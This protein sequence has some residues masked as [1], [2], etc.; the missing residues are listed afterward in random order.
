MHVR[1]MD[2][3]VMGMLSRA[4]KMPSLDA[5]GPL[6]PSLSSATLQQERRNRHAEAKAAPVENQHVPF[7]VSAFSLVL[8]LTRYEPALGIDSQ[9][10]SDSSI[11]DKED[12]AEYC[13]EEHLGSQSHDHEVDADGLVSVDGGQ[14]ASNANKSETDEVPKNKYGRKELR[15][16]DREAS[17]L[18]VP[19][20]GA[21]AK[22]Q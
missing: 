16:N 13:S 5:S 21:N 20:Q 22:V 1:I 18:I 7:R 12:S 17:C 15:A 2:I 6:N 14:G 9:L 11:E 10:A 3:K 19:L 4:I 8:K